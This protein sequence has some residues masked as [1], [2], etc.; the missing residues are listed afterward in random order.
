[1]KIEQRLEPCPFCDSDQITTAPDREFGD[2]TWL[3]LCKA[4][5]C[6][7][8]RDLE[9]DA[10]AAWNTRV[11]KRDDELADRLLMAANSVERY[12]YL[13][14][15]TCDDLRTAAAR[16]RGGER[17]EVAPPAH[18]DVGVEHYRHKVRGTTYEIVGVAE[19]Q[20]AGGQGRCE[21][22]QLVIYRGPNGI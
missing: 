15:V 19:L 14:N 10:I 2:V 20:D 13:P 22:A 18:N 6:R 21:G 4:C 17:E 1:M 9:A 11:T 16:L 7:V 5:G 8:E 12:P 3:A